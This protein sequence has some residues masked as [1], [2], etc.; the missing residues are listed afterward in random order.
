MA[1]YK[2]ISRFA[3]MLDDGYIYDVGDIYPREG[4]E[5]SDARYNELSSTRNKAGKTLITKIA[6]PKPKKQ[7]TKKD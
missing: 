3:D 1:S 7:K 6:E 5:V 4:L 2:V